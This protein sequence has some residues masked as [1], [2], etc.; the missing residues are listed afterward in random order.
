MAE[1]KK[2]P[3]K[4]TVGNRHK[5]QRKQSSPLQKLG[6][7]IR[8]S[9][10]YRGKTP[11]EKREKE[12]LR[13]K[14]RQ[15][16]LAKQE[17]SYSIERYVSVEEAMGPTIH[18]PLY[19]KKAAVYR[20]CRYVVMTA[21]IVF[22]VTMLNFFKDEITLENFRYLMRNVDFELRTELSE[23]GV[24]S[25]DSS[26]LNTFGVYKDSLVQLS[27]RKIA[28]YDAGGRSSYVGN[29]N[30]SSPSLCTSDKYVLAY[31]RQGGGYS[32]YT[33]FS[34][35][36]EGSTDFPIA[37][38]DLTDS[39][40]HVI[41]S[42][43][44][45]YTG[46]VSVYSASFQ[47]MNRIQKNKYIAAVDLSDDGKQLLIASY[48]VGERGIVT[49]LMTIAVNSD[50]PSLLFTVE[51]ILPWE[52]AWIGDGS[53]VLICDKGVKYYDET[54]KLYTEYGFSDQNVIE[55]KVSGSDGRI[56]LICREE[57]YTVGSHLYLLD[58]KGKT[59][60]HRKFSTTVG[61]IA[62]QKDQLILLSGST[63]WQIAKD[64]T[65]HRYDCFTNLQAAVWGGDTLYL[66]TPTRVVA[67]DW[68]KQSK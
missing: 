54:G 59:L 49:E 46:V 60:M 15:A 64:G 53:F 12:M 10:L 48:S 47:L 39:G 44:K 55:Y 34:Q 16:S 26:T 6:K 19:L 1:P 58:R 32:L 13:E 51:G 7:Q 57:N 8:L 4:K 68:K 18:N 3:T 43:S 38:A 41:A 23:P 50:T 33:G 45:A 20:I 25:Y 67:P 63:A 24:I 29:L 35:A 66:C 22:L 5:N 14:K 31:D 61:E 40:V 65:T 27:D 37:D 11:Q 52:A 28:I 56:A 21:L 62:F 36:Y 2:Q 17:E 30:Y 9:K 42:R